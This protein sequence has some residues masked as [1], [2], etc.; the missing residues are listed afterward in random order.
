MFVRYVP[1]GEADITCIL[2]IRFHRSSWPSECTCGY[3]RACQGRKWEVKPA[4]V[5]ILFPLYIPCVYVPVCVPLLDP[6]LSIH[7]RTPHLLH[8]WIRISIQVT[9]SRLISK[10]ASGQPLSTECSFLVL[11]RQCKRRKLRGHGARP[12]AGAAYVMRAPGHA[13][14]PRPVWQGGE[15]SGEVGGGRGGERRGRGSQEGRYTRE[16]TCFDGN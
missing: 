6:A 3:S 7:H 4:V 15:A 2:S 12:L 16:N 8:V 11:M 9:V 13:R 10:V 14:F 5:C 1:F